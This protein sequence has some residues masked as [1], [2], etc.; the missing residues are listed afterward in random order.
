MWHKRAGLCVKSQGFDNKSC[1]SWQGLRVDLLPPK[2]Y[3]NYKLTLST[4]ASKIF[5]TTLKPPCTSQAYFIPYLPVTWLEP[6]FPLYLFLI[7]G[8]T[9]FL[10]SAAAYLFL[11]AYQPTRCDKAR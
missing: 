6:S 2:N 11:A 9:R 8:L 5:F 4:A 10:S 1:N 3:R 7:I